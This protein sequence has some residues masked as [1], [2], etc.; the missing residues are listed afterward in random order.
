MPHSEKATHRKRRRRRAQDR[1]NRRIL[2]E[3]SPQPQLQAG[4]PVRRRTRVDEQAITAADT[5]YLDLRAEAH[6][7]LREI[8]SM[9]EEQTGAAIAAIVGAHIGPLIADRDWTRMAYVDLGA[10][11]LVFAEE[12]DRQRVRADRETVKAKSYRERMLAAEA[13]LAASTGHRARTIG[14]FLLGLT[15][16]VAGGAFVH[17]VLS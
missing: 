17:F 9:A 14:L 5:P 2:A 1:E 3:Q 10:R 6:G 8:R 13:D 11:M 16:A 15:S 7:A 12:R 4:Q